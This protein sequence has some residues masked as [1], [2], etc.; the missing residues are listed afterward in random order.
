[1]AMDYQKAKDR[2][3]LTQDRLK[4]AGYA[5]GSVAMDDDNAG[6]FDATKFE[7][8]TKGPTSSLPRGSRESTGYSKDQA[9]KANGGRT[10]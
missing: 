7:R 2:H 3:A 9:G 4:R 5:G 6:P 10:K 8:P 1:M